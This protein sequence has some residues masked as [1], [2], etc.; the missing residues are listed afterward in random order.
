MSTPKTA[1]IYLLQAIFFTI[2]LGAW[3][4]G[5]AA[6]Y[7]FIKFFDPNPEVFPKKPLSFEG[8]EYCVLSSRAKLGGFKKI[9]AEICET[10]S[11]TIGKR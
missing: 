2:F 11:L 4:T 7:R 5:V 10:I 9:Q 1:F 3:F 6:Y 8:L